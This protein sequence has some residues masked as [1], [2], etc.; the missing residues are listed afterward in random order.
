MDDRRKYAYRRIIYS[1]ILYIRYSVYKLAI[2][3]DLFYK[4]FPLAK[5]LEP[6]ENNWSF[7]RYGS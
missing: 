7:S 5:G 2:K 4:S 1:T 3:M 6:D